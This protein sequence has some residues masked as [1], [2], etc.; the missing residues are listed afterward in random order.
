MFQQ[1]ICPD[2]GTLIPAERMD[3][4]MVVCTC[5]Y[6]KSQSQVRF[7]KNRNKSSSYV[8][9]FLSLFLIASFIHTA[10]WGKDSVKVTPLEVSRVFGTISPDQALALGDMSMDKNFLDQAEKMYGIFLEANPDD[11][12]ANQKLGMLLF[13]QKKFEQ[14]AVYLE[15][16]FLEDGDD[17]IT[18]FSYGKSLTETQDLGDAEEVFLKLINAKPEMYQITVVQAL[19]D[20]YI[21]QGKLVEA[22]SFISS[23]IKPGYEVPTH[24]RE[25]KEH[26][27]DLL[28]KRS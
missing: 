21:E 28:T 3:E 12:D 25:Q 13:R 14:A 27:K 9:I 18:L 26:I 16:Y 24:L 15:K 17:Q 8:I 5:G 4:E 22:K 6:T 2:C 7:E 23:L 1:E 20:L 10:K 19:V 11:V